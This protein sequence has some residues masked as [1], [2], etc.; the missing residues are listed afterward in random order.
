MRRVQIIGGRDGS[1][2]YVDVADTANIQQMRKA[3]A[4]Q[5]NVALKYVKLLV[6]GPV[7]PNQ[8]RPLHGCLGCPFPPKYHQTATAQLAYSSKG[9]LSDAVLDE[10]VFV[11]PPA[12]ATRWSG[13][14]SCSG[15]C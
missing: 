1:P 5:C 9:V 11:V 7:P 12:G 3:V 8:V 6:N 13:G 2:G 10:A 15:Q 4:Q 14:H